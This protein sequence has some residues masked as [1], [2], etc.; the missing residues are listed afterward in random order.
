VAGGYRAPLYRLLTNAGYNVDFVG[1]QTG[2]GSASLPDPQHEGY[3]GWR[4]RQIDSILLNVF[5]AVPAPDIILLLLGP[6]TT[7]RTMTP[8]MPQAASKRSS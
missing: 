2:N 5:N 8:P 7:A 1:T 6:T 4:I 3:G